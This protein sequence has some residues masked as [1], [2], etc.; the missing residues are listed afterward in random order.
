[1]SFNR[2]KSPLGAFAILADQR[3]RDAFIMSAEGYTQAEIAK[4]L[5]ISVSG[6]RKLLIRAKDKFDKSSVKAMKTAALKAMQ[7]KL[8]Q[9][10]QLL[11][12]SQDI[13]ENL[14]AMEMYRKYMADITKLCGLNDADK[15]DVMSGGEPILRLNGKEWSEI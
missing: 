9:C 13:K 5:G 8:R 3:T 11:K 1:M 15:L 6:A 7:K 2:N 12:N 10:E 4:E 14:A